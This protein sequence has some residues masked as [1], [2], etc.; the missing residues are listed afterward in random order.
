MRAHCED[1]WRSIEEHGVRNKREMQ[2]LQTE[3]EDKDG[4]AES[5][6]RPLK[7]QLH[8]LRDRERED[9]DGIQKQLSSSSLNLSLSEQEY[10]SVHAHS[11]LNSR[12]VRSV[13]SVKACV[14]AL[15]E[16]AAHRGILG[17]DAGGA[18]TSTSLE[19]CSRFW[20]CFEVEFP[21]PL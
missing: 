14:E 8:E 16:T 10:V 12:S 6:N 15:R 18:A 9:A 13:D 11:H 7:R 3:H 1:L 4:D 21:F 5:A 17:D 2:R 20:S 19:S